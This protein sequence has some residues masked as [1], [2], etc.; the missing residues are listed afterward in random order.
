MIASLTL[1]FG[2]VSDFLSSAVPALVIR[3]AKGNAPVP[4]QLTRK[5]VKKHGEYYHKRRLRA[6]PEYLAERLCSQ[7]LP[8][9]RQPQIS[10][11]QPDIQNLDPRTRELVPSVVALA[12]RITGSGPHWSDSTS[13]SG[14]DGRPPPASPVLVDPAPYDF[15]EWAEDPQGCRWNLDEE[16][17]LSN[18]LSQQAFHMRSATS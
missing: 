4:A 15:P 12:L 16:M 17:K 6:T 8:Q 7:R 1:S 9:R 13:S 11:R 14:S 5:W 2:K 18:D 3:S 10:H